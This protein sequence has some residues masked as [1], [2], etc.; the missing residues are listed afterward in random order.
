MKNNAF[1]VCVCA[2]CECV[3]WEVGRTKG[4]CAAEDYEVLMYPVNVINF[5]KLQDM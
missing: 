5:D 2:V 4:H 3:S 1:C